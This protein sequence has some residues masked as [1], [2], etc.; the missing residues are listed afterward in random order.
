[1]EFKK[2]SAGSISYGKSNP[3][4]DKNR[5]EA[6]NVTNVN[7]EDSYVEN[8][9]NDLTHPN[10]YYLKR[11]LENLAVCHTVVVEYKNN[12]SSFNASSPDELALVQGANYLGCTFKGRDE[13]DNIN[14]LNNKTG[15]L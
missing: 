1:M 2:F 13:D 4:V 12:K 7:F 10:N 9:L 14:I 8:H 11:F 5:L 6:L 3:Q 15:E